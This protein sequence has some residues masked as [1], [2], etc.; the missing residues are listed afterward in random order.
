MPIFAGNKIFA[1]IK[2]TIIT[3]IHHARIYGA[4]YK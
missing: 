2:I 1:I 3:D 4:A